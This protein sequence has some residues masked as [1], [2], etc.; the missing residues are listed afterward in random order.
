[1][2]DTGSPTHEN[3][4]GLIP[5]ATLAR[6][7]TETKR[8]KRT[9]NKC[10]KTEKKTEY[11]ITPPCTTTYSLSPLYLL[12]P[13][14]SCPYLYLPIA[15]TR[16]WQGWSPLQT[17]GPSQASSGRFIKVSSPSLAQRRAPSP[18]LPT[19]LMHIAR[20]AG[21]GRGVDV[22]ASGWPV[23]ILPTSCF[24]HVLI[25]SI[26]VYFIIYYILYMPI[27]HMLSACLSGTSGGKVRV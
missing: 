2:A 22:A 6:Q 10:T 4:Q 18:S 17:A 16:T 9:K 1:M 26:L 27:S 24:H 14:A 5:R 7:G 19:I 8:T 13:A 21:G 23:C 11:I 12:F 3:S 20:K 25:G 15:W